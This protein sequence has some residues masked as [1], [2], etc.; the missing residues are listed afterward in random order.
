M[1]VTNRPLRHLYLFFDWF[2]ILS[3]FMIFLDVTCLGHWPFPTQIEVGLQPT[4]NVSN[5]FTTTTTTRP[6]T[7]TTSS[8]SPVNYLLVQDRNGVSRC[9]EY[10]YQ[11]FDS[12]I[13]NLDVKFYDFECVVDQTNVMQTNIKHLTYQGACQEALTDLS[14]ISNNAE[15]SNKAQFK[16]IFLTAIILVIAKFKLCC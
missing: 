4:I 2:G 6:T 14:S 12:R 11:S 10:T 3:F 7:A 1:Y 8:S 5:H 15:I 9:L 16:I 13:T